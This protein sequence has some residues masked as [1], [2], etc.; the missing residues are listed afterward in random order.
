V[1]GALEGLPGV[2][3]TRTD[4]IRGTVRVRYDG[5]LVSPGAFTPALESRGYA[6]SPLPQDP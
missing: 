1:D 5:N 4:V 6:V 2:Y 3:E